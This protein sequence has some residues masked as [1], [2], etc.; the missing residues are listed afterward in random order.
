MQVVCESDSNYRSQNCRIQ[1]VRQMLGAKTARRFLQT[2]HLHDSTR[3]A[4]D[5]CLALESKNEH[6]GGASASSRD[7]V[8]L[9]GDVAL[10]CKG[11]GQD[12]PKKA[13]SKVQL[14]KIDDRKCPKCVRENLVHWQTPSGQWRST[15]RK[16]V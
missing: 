3:R 12:L 5:A 15:M 16:D 4:C 1:E 7:N 14:R 8:A 2:Q 6:V 9:Q 11:C 13:Y 10:R